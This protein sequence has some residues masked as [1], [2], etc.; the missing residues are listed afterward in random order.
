[1][2]DIHN[3]LVLVRHAESIGNLSAREADPVLRDLSAGMNQKDWPLTE[4]SRIQVDRT[5]RF[6]K[7]VLNTGIRN[8]NL[9]TSSSVRAKSTALG[10]GLSEFGDWRVED[11]L[12]EMEL[13]VFATMPEEEYKEKYPIANQV[14]MT[15]QFHWNPEGGESFEIIANGRVGRVL[16]EINQSHPDDISIVVSH[17]SVMQAMRASIEQQTPAEFNAVFWNKGDRPNFAEARYYLN[18]AL[19]PFSNQLRYT[20]RLTFDP[21]QPECIAP[22]SIVPL[23]Q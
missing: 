15:D 10:L 9:M 17:S 6:I 11:D 18:D 19:N 7:K 14:R 21:A 5:A 1:M 2:R 23:S 12:R 3:R 4:R 16:G 13:G 20:D 22:K 8:V